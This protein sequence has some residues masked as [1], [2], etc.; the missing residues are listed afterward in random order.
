VG[1]SVSLHQRL[2]AA[3]AKLR[4]NTDQGQSDPQNSCTDGQ[5]SPTN[6]VPWDWVWSR[7]FCELSLSRVVN[8]MGESWM[9]KRWKK[10]IDDDDG[11][12]VVFYSGE[13]RPCSACTLTI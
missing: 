8:V 2:Q 10:R 9:R 11:G 5:A 6:L 1:L 4:W 3:A 13:L 7:A 12:A